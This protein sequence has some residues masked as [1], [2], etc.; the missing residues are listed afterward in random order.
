MTP[1]S[2]SLRPLFRVVAT[3]LLAAYASGV[4]AQDPTEADLHASL[5]APGPNAGTDVLLRDLAISGAG[6]LAS[7]VS[8]LK[9]RSAVLRQLSDNKRGE[10]EALESE[11][12]AIE[13]FLASI[14]SLAAPGKPV[15][16][17][18]P[19]VGAPWERHTIEHGL[20]SS[21]GIRLG[22]INADG[23]LD[24][25]VAWE[26]QQV[27]RV[28]LN[29]GPE[30][31]GNG[32]WPAVTVA[33]TPNVE[34]AAFVDLDRDGHLDV[35]SSQEKGSEKVV[36]AWGP[37]DPQAVLQPEAWKHDEFLQVANVTMWM[38]AEPIQL[39]PGA[40]VSL[41]IGG[42]NYKADASAVLGILVAPQ[43]NPRNLAAWQ[44][45]PLTDVSWVMAIE[46]RD[47]DADGYEDILFTDKHGPKAGVHWLKNPGANGS[48]WERHYLTDNTV[49]SANFLTLADLDEDG[50]EDIVALVELER[51]PG[52]PNHAHRRVLFFRRTD[53]ARAEWTTYPILVPPGIGS[54]KGITVGDVDLDGRNDIVLT[55]SGAEGDLIGTSWLRYEGAP[56][57]PVWRA[58]N[59]A[60]PL[61]TKYDLV[62]LL[63]LDDDGDLDV[64]ANDENQDG[65][66][67]GVF[68]Y[69]NPTISIKHR[70]AATR[71]AS[72]K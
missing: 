50:L 27:S 1:Q 38:Y 30:A 55:S 24:L 35:V 61:G 67:L 40:P 8:E 9:D 4:S 65:I 39:A 14:S 15:D 47:L 5:A 41:V 71:T 58:Y 2:A 72:V 31:A 68:W 26:G 48:Q 42:K 66:G 3:T 49:K 45:Q 12:E 33:T 51:Q 36:V 60:G 37:E 46:A 53:A 70:N 18:L 19:P 29:P 11:A 69:E 22:D 34:D 43:D 62:H 52:A 13:T 54:S 44:W 6:A 17:A 25:S 23:R 20:R 21:E 7:R 59:I 63:D 64:L 16:G 57:D 10:V 32:P 56:T 28:Y